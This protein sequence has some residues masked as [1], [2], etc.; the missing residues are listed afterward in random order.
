[1]KPPRCP[2]RRKNPYSGWHIQSSWRIVLVFMLHFIAADPG[3]WCFFDSGI[4]EK[5]FS[6]SQIQPVVFKD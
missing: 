2:G 1:M 6:G 4:R 3:V 5:F